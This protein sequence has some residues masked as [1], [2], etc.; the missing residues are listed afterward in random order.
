MSVAS[1]LRLLV[2]T[3]YYHPAVVYGGPVPAIAAFNK[4]LAAL[5]HEITVLTTDANGSSDLEVPLGQPVQVE[6]LP[7][8][9]FPRW[10]F[11]RKRKPFNLFFCPEMGKALRRLKPGDYDVIMSHAMF[12][13]PGRLAAAAA[14]KAGTPYLCYTH[15]TFEPWAIHHKYWKK[16]LYLALIEGRLLNDAAGV[17]VCNDGE[18][19]QLRRMGITTPIRRIPWGVAIPPPDHMPPRSRLAELWPPLAG[20]PFILFLSRLHPKKGLDL[21]IPAFGSLADAF[22]D[23]LLV[24]AGPDEGG[25][26]QTLEKMVQES[27]LE[28]RVIFPGLVTGEA[29]ATL[30]SQADLFVLPSYSEGFPVVVAEA[31]GYGRPVVLTTTCYVPEAAQGGAGLETPPEKEP[32]TRALRVAMRDEGFRRRCADSA[33]KVARQYFTWESVAEQN[34]KFIREILVC[35]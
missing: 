1:P 33:H 13:D 19:E 5:G 32:L 28:H 24:L 7:V 20:R 27:H 25:Y 23:W 22:P 11:G 8:T 6:G 31:L 9:Y 18:K 2:I 14:K 4:T 29:K 16:K 35:R 10:W 3:S 17:V 15:G 26:R 30:L 21:L 34:L 12:C